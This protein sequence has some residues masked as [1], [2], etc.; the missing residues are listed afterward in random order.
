MMLRTALLLWSLLLLYGCKARHAVAEGMHFTKMDAG[1]T[2]I[3]FSN[4]ITD[5]DSMNVF[6]DEYMYNGSGVGVGDLNG[7]GLP[8][9][10]FCGGMVSSRLYINKGNFIFEDVTAAAGLQTLK[11]CTG[12]SVAD[13]NHDGFPDLYVCASHSTARDRRKNMLFINDGKLHFTDQAD[14]YGLADTGYS[15]QAA[16][17]DYDRDGDL[18]M[19][20]LNHQ[21]YS[22]TA[23]DLHPKDTS[24]HAMAQDRLYRNDGVPAGM[25]HPVFHDVSAAAGIKEDG[26]GLG[27]VVTD[28][29][30]DGWPD[31]YVANDYLANDLLWLNNRNGTFTN[32]IATALRHQSYNSMGTDAADINNDG[33]PDLAVVDMLPETN[34]RKKMMG[35]ATSQSKFDMQQ[36]L[37]YEPSYVRNMLQ[38]NNGSRVSVNGREEPF[39]SEIGQL[40]GIFQTDWSWSVLMADLDNDGWKDIYITNGLGKDVTNN[41]YTTFTAAQGGYTGSYAFGK[42]R[43]LDKKDIT[44]M[45]KNLDAYGSVKMESYIFHNKGDLRFDDVSE[46]AGV[47][48]PAITNGAV[49]ADLDN[50]GDLDLV[51][52]NINQEAF[53]W[54]NDLRVSAGDSV[55]NFISFVGLSIGSKVTLFNN[56]MRQFLEAGPVRGFSS[57]VDDRLHF[58]VGNAGVVD[59]VLVQWPDEQVEVMR[60]VKTNQFLRVRH[61]DAVSPGIAGSVLAPPLFTAGAGLDFKHAETF[62]YDFGEHQPLLQKFSQLGPCLALADVN[63]DGL[64]DV[65]VGGAANQSGKIFL[66]QGDGGFAGA[67]LVQGVKFEEDL[68][69]IFFDADGD[70]DMDLLITGGSFEFRALSYNRPRLYMND[71]KGHFTLAADALPKITDVTKAVVAFDYDGDGDLDLF[72]GG[73]LAPSKFPQSPRSYILQN[74][75]GRFRDVTHAVCP[76][77]ETPG[78]VTDAL[79]MDRVEG[80]GLVICGEW[81]GVRSFTVAGGR[82]TETTDA[83]GLSALRGMWRC[84]MAV[85]LDKDGDQDLV[86]GNMGLNNRYG[87]AAGKPMMLYAK[88]MDGNGM[89]ELVPAYYIKD[90]HGAYQLYPALDRNQLAQQLPGVKKKYLLHK[91]YAAVTMAQL[92]TDFGGEGWTG[93]TC[94]TAASIWLENLGGGK[95]RPHILPVQAQLAPVNSIVA[96]DLDGDGAIDLVVAG[97]EYQAESNTGRADASYGLVMKGDGKGNFS[98]MDIAGSGLILDGDV[99]ALRMVQGMVQ[100]KGRRQLL[101]A[102]NDSQLKIF[103]VR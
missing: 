15:T 94:E 32:V 84:M 47:Q 93:L 35:S 99:R 78:M 66:Q 63:G 65:F 59:S 16:F 26:Y 81:M 79:V 89:E 92:K 45:R 103:T 37:G 2:H 76:A 6:I 20:L 86:L 53:V 71:G 57:S 60:H 61:A 13:V 87:M 48:V 44:T 74:D 101:V 67:D 98:P 1:A 64:E 73:R 68:G 10:F 19:Y 38:L 88:D 29:N 50:D 82:L 14:A 31:V 39:F 97:N 36:R 30:K 17:F 100:V 42:Q 75:H 43:V 85:D 41:D 22:H 96:E 55:H 56:G 62:N 40:A 91:D 4:V 49:Y 3:D 25:D 46:A 90:R 58:G 52:N 72:I 11:W 95:F 70:K 24:G 21:I 12:V 18:D 7:D 77:L 80:K 34:E 9:L 27:M 28:I 69:A 54:R 23:N 5:S 51:S 102:P 33:L 83:A 8:D